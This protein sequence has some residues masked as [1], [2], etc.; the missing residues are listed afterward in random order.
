MADSE[1][2]GAIVLLTYRDVTFEYTLGDADEL[3]LMEVVGF[4]VEP[5]FPGCVSVANERAHDGERRGVTTVLRELVV[6]LSVIRAPKPFG[7][8]AA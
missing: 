8:V 3:K 7:E 5:R 6:D 1:A 4:L 2:L